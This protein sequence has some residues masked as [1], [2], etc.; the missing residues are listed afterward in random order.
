MAVIV[1]VL[2]ASTDEE[3]EGVG[4]VTVADAV[5]GA[6]SVG[7]GLTVKVSSTVLLSVS[8]VE[9]IVIDRVDSSVALDDPVNASTVPVT[10]LE[11]IVAGAVSE[12]VIDSV[13][14]AVSDS[15]TVDVCSIECVAERHCRPRRA[16]G[17]TCSARTAAA[18][19]NAAPYFTLPQ[20]SAVGCR[21]YH[22]GEVCSTKLFGKK[23]H[24]FR[25]C[26]RFDWSNVLPE[27]AKEAASRTVTALLVVTQ[28][29]CPEAAA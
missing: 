18:P 8:D 23:I 29:A 4:A 19:R 24:G 28:P 27:T 20:K 2:G 10:K 14:T 13:R 12:M 7:A 16:W 26:A 21:S 11:E 17:V 22:C 1:R 9:T 6:V 5:E 3:R 15:V 25:V